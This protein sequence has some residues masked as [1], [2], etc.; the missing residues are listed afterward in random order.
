MR[1]RVLLL[2]LD[3]SLPNLALAKLARWHEDRGDEVLWNLE[4]AAPTCDLVY[5]SAIFSWTDTSTVRSW[6]RAIVGGTGVD[7]KLELSPEIEA[8]RPRINLGFASRGCV[9]KCDFCVVPRKEGNVRPVGDLLDLWDGKARR[10]KLLDNNALALPDHF[11]LVCDQAKKNKVLVD[12]T[13]GLDHRLLTPDLAKLLKA[14]PHVEKWRF[15][16]DHPSSEPT[17]VRAI[18]LLQ[19]AGINRADWYVLVGFRTTHREDLARLALL[20]RLNQR[21]YVMVYRTKERP[22]DP[23]LP[24]LQQYANSFRNF[25]RYDFETFLREVCPGHSPRLLAAYLAQRSRKKAKA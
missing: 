17:V 18:E 6:P 4:L 10:V 19:K 7:L 23:R 14:T 20:R 2:Q 11:R 5:A 8:V 22:D 13:Q 24:L 16:F 9:R 3:G 15:A 21:A 25:T 1:S 12:F